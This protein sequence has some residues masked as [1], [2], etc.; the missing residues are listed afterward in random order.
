M[1]DILAYLFGKILSIHRERTLWHHDVK[2]SLLLRSIYFPLIFLPLPDISLFEMLFSE[3]C[4]LPCS[5]LAI[6]I[7]TCKLQIS[8]FFFLLQR[9]SP[10]FPSW[11]KRGTLKKSTS[12]SQKLHVHVSCRRLLT[13]GGPFCLFA[14]LT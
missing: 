14:T 13:D 6:K 5:H 8:V 7:C 12:T 9:F 4:C 3:G 10:P 1:D 11:K 2:S